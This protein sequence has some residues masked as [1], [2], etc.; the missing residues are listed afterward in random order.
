MLLWV[1]LGCAVLWHLGLNVDAWYHLHYGF[2]IETFFTGAHALIYG[3]WLA[4]GAVTMLYVVESVVRSEGRENW[5][6]PGFRLVLFGLA[7]FGIGGSID[8]VWHSL[9]GFEV[10]FD[11][12]VT[13]PHLLLF[14]SFVLSV[15]GLLNAAIVF[16]G[17]G[18]VG[19]WWPRWRDVPTIWIFAILFGVSLY[20]LGW[21]DPFSVDYASGGMHARSVFGYAGLDFGGE[22]ARVAGVI[23]I[24]LHCLLQSVFIIC[25][26]R[27]LRLP[28]GYITAAMLWVGLILVAVQEQW[29]FLPAAL[30]GALVGEVI[31]WWI[32]HGGFGGWSDPRGYWLLAFLIPV[33]EFLVYDAL[34]AAVGGGLVWKIHLWAGAP[35]LAGVFSTLVAVLIV[36]PAFLT[37]MPKERWPES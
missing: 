21:V 4:F 36:P 16:R 29:T 10:S 35:F 11:A 33:S 7:L 18:D 19:S 6:P 8:L 28:G 37:T 27:L 17:R 26:L 15:L 31:W 5:V 1:A 14:A 25:P 24:V 3:G 9:T 22:T 12:L 20:P 13:P 2:E 23:G 32:R 34:V 30:V